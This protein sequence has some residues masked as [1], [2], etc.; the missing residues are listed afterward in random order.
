MS[1]TAQTFIEETFGIL[2]DDDLYLDCILVRPPDLSD[3]DL[4]AIRVWVPKY[5]LTKTSVLTCARQEVL[6]NGAKRK[7]AHLVF[8]LRGTG[9][10]EGVMGSS[11]FDIDLHAVR[12]WANERFL[13]AKVGFLGTPYSEHGRVN[14]WPLRPGSILESYH[15]AASSSNVSSPT[16]LYLSTYG[17]FGNSDDAVCARLAKAGYDVYGLDP[18]RYLLHAS[19]RDRLKPED[20]WEDLQILVQMLPGRPIVMGQPVSAGL[21]LL[22]A[23]GVKHVEGV[24]SIGQA[25]AAFK[26]SH[27]FHNNNPYTF[28]LNRYLPEISPQPLTFVMLT[29]HSLGG[30]A[31]EM[32]TLY[33]SSKDPHRLER[34]S[35]LRFK[36]L[37]ELI[38]W[39]RNPQ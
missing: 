15:Y 16:L 39:T 2:T 38:E 14:M 33:T 32:K 13:Q 36:F 35:K 12:E 11:E 10:S 21:A 30:D 34:A 22:W 27:I 8:D 23:S 5:P 37:L 29:G 20:L 24:I 9:E 25:Q 19:S 26:P 31:A 4:R 17:R 28:L 6:Y 1:A 18:L 3:D 7:T